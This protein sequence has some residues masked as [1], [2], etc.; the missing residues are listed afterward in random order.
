[1]ATN[2]NSP[3]TGDVVVPTDV[4]Y[5]NYIFMAN[6]ALVWPALSGTANGNTIFEFARIID[7]RATAANLTLRLPPANQGSE[8]EDVLI[9]NVGSNLFSVTRND[10]TLPVNLVP[11]QAQ[12][13][14]LVDNTTAAGAWNS[15]QFGAGTALT[16]AASLAGGGLLVNN[17]A[18]LGI[19]FPVS[20]ASLNPPVFSDNSLGQTFVWT[21]GSD[22][23][24]LPTPSINAWTILVRNNGTGQLTLQ[25]PPS[26]EIDKLQSIQL[27]PGES[28][29]VIYQANN[30]ENPPRPEYFT[31]GRNRLSNF[32]FSSGVTDVSNIADGILD[33]S[34]YA[35]IIQRYRNSTPTVAPITV[36]LPPSTNTYY[37]INGSSSTLTF[38]IGVPSPVGQTVTIPG[39]T[40]SSIIA[41]GTNLYAINTAPYGALQLNPSTKTNP[42]L[43]IAGEATGVWAQSGETG[44]TVTGGSAY[45]QVT[46]TQVQINA[47]SF[48]APID[49][50]Y[51]A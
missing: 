36:Y 1:M 45:V 10:G 29:F 11:G 37:I 47:A 18:R 33:S 24:T 42:A 35:T 28:T 30:G 49:G 6:A 26:I 40:Q 21:G 31:I 27:L 39:G 41:D 22:T 3:F 4:S 7:A 12:W 13:F 50:G 8:G 17:N 43:A 25:P 15:V 46:P 48:I 5:G 23:Y 51:I 34:A 20:Q 2:F 19:G 9:R 14:Y 32:Y 16:D 38:Q 44:L